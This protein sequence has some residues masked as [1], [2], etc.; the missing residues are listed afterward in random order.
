MVRDLASRELNRDH[1]DLD[2]PEHLFV[3]SDWKNE[4][5]ESFAPG[6]QNHET[7]FI[8]NSILINGRGVRINVSKNVLIFRE[9]LK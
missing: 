4:Y 2:L 3:L 1:Y 9:I 5:G 7:K 8:P 6:L